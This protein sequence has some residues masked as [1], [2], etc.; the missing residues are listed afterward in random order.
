MNLEEAKLALQAA[1][2]EDSQRR[3]LP[4]G[5]DAM[6]LS[7]EIAAL[8]N[9]Q[10]GKIFWGISEDGQVEGLA[11][12]SLARAN[13]VLQAAA[14]SLVPPVVVHTQNIP[15]AG[16]RLVVVVEVPE[17]KKP[18][19]DRE[20][21]L[22]VK[23]AAG[24]ILVPRNDRE[25]EHERGQEEA[26][27]RQRSLSLA[28]LLHGEDKPRAKGRNGKGALDAL[29]AVK[30][31]FEARDDARSDAGVDVKDDAMG[32]T[33]DGPMDG[34]MAR[35]RDASSAGCKKAT[36]PAAEFGARGTASGPDF[37]EAKDMSPMGEVSPN[38]GMKDLSTEVQDAEKTKEFE[39]AASGAV[40]AGGQKQFEKIFRFDANSPEG[41]EAKEVYWLMK[42]NV[43][44]TVDTMSVH[45][46]RSRRTVL[47]RVARLK[48]LG[49]LVRHGTSR[50]GHWEIV[51]EV[52]LGLGLE[53]VQA[54][55]GKPEKG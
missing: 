36:L 4:G 34:A 26:H 17:G 13:R 48:D 2:G 55:D 51:P 15:L 38:A 54:V 25:R 40:C 1:L 7:C 21:R 31:S 30:E 20:G 11:R 47:K 42:N 33:M 8:A 22:W 10:G 18:C 52:A 43:N 28:S 24:R 29:D 14:E 50:G 5:E 12:E 37:A 35:H 46:G 39:I 49:V 32:G 27:P 23:S 6:T 45:L 41:Q 3:F 19:L 16:N 44:V 9:T 53:E